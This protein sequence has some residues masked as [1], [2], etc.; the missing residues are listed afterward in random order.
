VL[1]DAVLRAADTWYELGVEIVDRVGVRF[2]RDRARPSVYDAN[3]ARR[4]G[5]DVEAAA[6]LAAA[7]ELFAESDHRAVRL[8]PRSRAAELEAAL[9]LAGYACELQLLMALEGPLRGRP[10]RARITPVAGDAAWQ[11]FTRLKQAEYD[12]DGLR[13]PAETWCG[14]LRAKT[15]PVV[16]WLADLDG[17]PVGFFS[18]LVCG[19]AAYLEDL[20]VRP[21]ARGRGVA[22]ALVAHAVEH[23]RQQGA[24]FCALAARAD[25]T[26]KDMYARMGF[27]PLGVTRSLLRT[28]G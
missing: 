8:D 26:P 2:L 22:T 13:L 1:L 24:A 4:V 17:E 21:D 5:D 7:D 27:R 10:G 3:H 16:T 6:L 19:G 20:Y 12:A 18:A 9:L 28:G 23:S 15:P 25:D 11:V 14:H